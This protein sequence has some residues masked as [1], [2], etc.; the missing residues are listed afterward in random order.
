M[1]ALGE[2]QETAD[3]FSGYADEFERND[4][5]DHALP[6]DPLAGCPFAQPERAEALRRLGRDHAVQLSR[7]RWPAGPSRPRSSPATP[8]SSRARATRRG[9]GA[10]W[11]TA[12]ATRASRAG[13]FNYVIGPGPRRGRGAHRPPRSRRRHVHRLRSTSAWAST[14]RWRPAPWPRPCIAEM[15]GKNAC[16]VTAHGDLD[17]AATGIVR[18]AFGMTRA[19]VLGPLAGVRGGRRRRRAARAVVGRRRRRI[20]V[21]DPTP[22][23]E[24][25]GPGDLG[26]RRASFER[27]CA[28]LREGGGPHPRRRH[29]AAGTATSRT[30]TSS[31]PTR[32][33]GAA[34]PPALPGGDVPA[35]PHGGRVA[36]PRGGPAP[37]PTT[38]TLGLTAGCYGNDEEVARSSIASRPA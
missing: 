12:S 10:S 13:V 38:A 7:W 28:R 5:Y 36:G 35:H 32:G 4:G 31:R 15:G 9:P 6:D 27:Y 34:R 8:S 33:R 22:A 20:R 18:S 24:L 26:A 19:E 25:D 37:A 2:T 21:G 23:R 17:R 16:I 29:P 30:A 1:E 3:F 14:A 11:P